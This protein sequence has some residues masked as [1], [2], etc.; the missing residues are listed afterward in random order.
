MG[1]FVQLDRIVQVLLVEGHSYPYVQLPRTETRPD[2]RETGLGACTCAGMVLD[3]DGSNVRNM[4]ALCLDVRWYVTIVAYCRALRRI[5]SLS[6]VLQSHGK[7][8]AL[9][10]PAGLTDIRD[11]VPPLKYV[12]DDHL[13][14]PEQAR[15][16][17]LIIHLLPTLPNAFPVR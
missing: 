13:I 16:L 10:P 5:W 8:G 15:V 4:C 2:R 11:T 17:Y 6:Q 7:W 1:W 14:A 12:D 9:P 3:M